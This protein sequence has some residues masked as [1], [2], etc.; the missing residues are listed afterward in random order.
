MFVRSPSTGA[1]LPSS[2]RSINSRNRA[3]SGVGPLQR[4]Q[5]RQCQLPGRQVR[6]QRFANQRF[7]P[8][9]IEAIV[10]NLVR[11]PHARPNWRNP[12]RSGAVAPHSQPR[13]FAGQREQFA[14]FHFEHLE[15]LLA[16]QTELPDADGLQD[17]AGQ[18]VLVLQNSPADFRVG[19]LGGQLS[20]RA[21]TV[22][23]GARN[24][25]RRTV[26][27]VLRTG[28]LAVR[29]TAPERAGLRQFGLALGTAVPG[30]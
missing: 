23:Q 26:R 11:R 28:R 29:A 5:H 21:R 18:T 17:F 9:K 6:A 14:V 16:R 19:K 20:V 13:Q 27:A 7:A 8:E 4:D 12:A 15:V 10:I 30:L 2:Q 22:L 1:T 3:R 25:D 24:E